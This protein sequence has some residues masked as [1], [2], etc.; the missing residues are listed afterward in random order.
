VERS[1]AATG[2]AA[3][4]RSKTLDVASADKKDEAMN[5]F[6]KQVNDAYNE[7]GYP[8]WRAAVNEVKLLMEARAGK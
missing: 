4:I 1:H 6:R 5:E 7:S 8:L 2:R 3:L